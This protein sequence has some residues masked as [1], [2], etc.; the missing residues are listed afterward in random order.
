MLLQGAA[1]AVQLVQLYGFWYGYSRATGM[2]ER[3]PRMPSDFSQ[4]LEKALHA[5]SRIDEGVQCERLQHHFIVELCAV[6]S[7]S[8]ITHR[9]TAF[10]VIE[11]Q[12]FTMQ[13]VFVQICIYT[14]HSPSMHSAFHCAVVSDLSMCIPAAAWYMP[15]QVYSRL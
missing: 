11:K 10:Q 5:L 2:F 3:V 13:I 12:Q 7:I 15:V 8:S 4:Q 14:A 1:S 6:G 9:Y